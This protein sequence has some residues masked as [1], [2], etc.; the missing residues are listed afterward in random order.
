MSFPDRACVRNRPGRRAHGTESHNRSKATCTYPVFHL[1][2]G[3]RF[4]SPH[5]AGTRYS[6]N[7]A[8]GNRYSGN[9]AS[10]NRYLKVPNP[11]L[12]S[13][14][15]MAPRRAK[16]TP[17][18]QTLLSYRV[19]KLHCVNSYR[20]L[21]CR[22]YVSLVAAEAMDPARLGLERIRGRKNSSSSDE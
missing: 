17:P 5:Y 14:E 2:P 7:F 11:R 19:L 15:R 20:R 12:R 6:G 3:S 16:M 18:S 4:C 21:K 8:S 9:F 22:T 13:P 10:G 1:M